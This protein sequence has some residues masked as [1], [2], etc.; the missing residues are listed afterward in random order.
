[1]ACFLPLPDCPVAFHGAD[2]G[3]D[4]PIRRL[5]DLQRKRAGFEGNPGNK[6]LIR[7]VLGH[8]AQYRPEAA[9]EFRPKTRKLPSMPKFA[10]SL[11]RRW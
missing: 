1:M 5:A 11:S 3:G 4:F 9:K 6:V 8:L 7:T 10:A 2:Q